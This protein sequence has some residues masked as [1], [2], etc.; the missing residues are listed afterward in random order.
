MGR[1][2]VLRSA[3]LAAVISSATAFHVAPATIRPQAQPTPLDRIYAA[4]SPVAAAKPL[5]LTPGLWWSTACEQVTSESVKGFAAAC[6]ASSIS[7]IRRHTTSLVAFTVGVIVSQLIYRLRASDP[8]DASSTVMVQ[9][10][11]LVPKAKKQAQAESLFF[12]PPPEA[13]P[14]VE[15]DPKDPWGSLASAGTAFF[16]AAVDATLATTSAVY[17]IVATEEGGGGATGGSGSGAVAK[18]SGAATVSEVE[19]A[20]KEVLDASADERTAETLREMKALVGEQLAAIKSLQDQNA[21]LQAKL[22]ASTDREAELEAKLADTGASSLGSVF[23]G[24]SSK[25]GGKLDG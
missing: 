11:V 14:A 5:L 24:L 3:T 6:V 20:S 7:I 12:T 10:T 2:S 4:A 15:V 22:D 21:E 1:P 25:I 8:K 18:G 13:K 16:G 9:K 17:D 23:K 19:A